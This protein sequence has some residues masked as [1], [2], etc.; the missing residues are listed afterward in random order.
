MPC[1]NKPRALKS[2]KSLGKKSFPSN[3]SGRVL[4]PKLDATRF[5]FVQ[6]ERGYRDS[7]LTIPFAFECISALLRKPLTVVRSF[8]RSVGLSSVNRGIYSRTHGVTQ[9]CEL[10]RVRCFEVARNLYP[11]NA[12]YVQPYE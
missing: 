7:Q 11:R 3:G 2:E 6:P 10:F 4:F 1:V 8:V 9:K 5:D 12:N